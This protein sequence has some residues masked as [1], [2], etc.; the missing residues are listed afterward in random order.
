MA[1]QLGNVTLRQLRAVAALASSGSITGAARLLNLTQPAIT[2]QLR[3]LQATAELP[4]FQRTGEGMVL[5][6]AGRELLQLAERIEASILDCERTLDLMSGRSGGR[7]SIG[8]VSTAKYFIPFMIAAFSRQRPNVQVSLSIGNRMQIMQQLRRYDL[9]F[10]V[11]GRPP[12][13]VAVERHLIGDHPHVVVAPAHHRLA[14]RKSL[15]IGDLADDVFLTRE[16]GSG[17]RILMERLFEEHDVVPTIGMEFDS[18]ETIK[19]G[20]I[21]GLG[22]AFISAHTVASELA[23]RRLVTLACD[24]LPVVRQWYVMRRSDKV[25]LPPAQAAFDFMVAEAPRLLPHGFAL[26]PTA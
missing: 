8:A 12:P 19:Q 17:T 20:V 11:M 13:D 5:T 21:A 15:A 4:L 3:N 25:L 18:N 1:S 23:D 9:D 14:G 16:V 26:P 24:G 2:L 22:I 7:V 6:D 10:A